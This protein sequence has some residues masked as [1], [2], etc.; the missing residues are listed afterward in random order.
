MKCRFRK[1]PVY[2]EAQLGTRLEK[3]TNKMTLALPGM[4]EGDSTAEL[5][6]IIY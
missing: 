1:R 5:L 6:K 4:Q 3:D 2:A